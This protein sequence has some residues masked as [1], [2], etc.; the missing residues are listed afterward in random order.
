MVIN[1]YGNMINL[2]NYNYFFYK[3]LKK[4]RDQKKYKDQEKY[5]SKS[6]QQQTNQ[7]EV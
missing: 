6:L 1:P 5:F 4:I 3:Q 7:P 2:I